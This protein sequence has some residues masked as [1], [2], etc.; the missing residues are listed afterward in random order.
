ML[1]LITQVK[2]YTYIYPLKTWLRSLACML[3]RAYQ[4]L[5]YSRMCAP[6]SRCFVIT[7]HYLSLLPQAYTIPSVQQL[8]VL[9]KG[10]Y[11]CDMSCACGSQEKDLYKT[12]MMLV[13][14]ESHAVRTLD[15]TGKLQ[16]LV[17][18]KYI[19][20]CHKCL[21]S[22]GFHLWDAHLLKEW[23]STTPCSAALF[24][25]VYGSCTHSPVMYNSNRAAW[26]T[27]LLTCPWSHIAHRCSSL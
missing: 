3:T 13:W 23:G 18:W 16:G 11:T 27:F 2:Y 8:S 4:L 5:A 21:I 15:C 25:I 12:S 17:S 7:R 10:T 6:F 20:L 26:M 9:M 19:K 14:F 1:N 24:L 22:G